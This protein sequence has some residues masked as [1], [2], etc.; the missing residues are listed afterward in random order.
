MSTS[1]VN[2]ITDL[3]QSQLLGRVATQSNEPES[4]ILRGFETTLGAMISGLASKSGQAGFTQQVSDLIRSPANNLHILDNPAS[5]SAAP[6]TDSLTSRF[7]STVFGSKMSSIT[8]AIGSVSGLRLGTVT[9]LMNVG[10]PL[11]LASL[12]KLVRERNLDSAGVANLLSREATEIQGS[13]PTP[14]RTAVVSDSTTEPIKMAV[15]PEERRR[16]WLWPA[17]LGALALLALIWWLAARTPRVVQTAAEPAAA[18]DFVTRNLPDNV[19]LRIPAGRM[20]DHLLA[21]IQD[22]S[23]PADDTTWFDFDRLLFDTDSAT[24]QPSSQEQLH[25]VAE[26]LKAYPNVHVKI[27]GYTDNT[28]DAS[29]NLQLSQ[30]R[31]DDVKQQLVAMGIAGDRLEAQGYGEDHPVADNSTADGRQKN[32]RISLRV[33]KNK[34]LTAARSD[35]HGCR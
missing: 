16:S 30:Q 15:V 3:F 12:G 6:S 21:F 24:L 8:G 18:S 22:P 29:H 7:L 25:N 14:I 19:D 5:V 32:R 4:S 2:G 33:L 27:G 20:E 10:A 1:L 28:G 17:I 26:I 13:I 11:L 31:A 9:S 35:E 34:F 23:K